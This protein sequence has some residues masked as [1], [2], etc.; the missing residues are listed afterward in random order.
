LPLD[1]HTCVVSGVGVSATRFGLE[2]GVS[3]GSVLAEI[4]FEAHGSCIRAIVP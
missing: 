4:L 2:G 3:L 1:L